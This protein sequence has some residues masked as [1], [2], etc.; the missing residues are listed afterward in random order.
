MRLLHRD[1]DKRSSSLIQGLIKEL[2]NKW[3]W[4]G[5]LSMLIIVTFVVYIPTYYGGF[6]WDDDFNFVNNP[7]MTADDGLKLIWVSEEAFYY[8]LV[9]TTFW[10]ERQLWG[11]N[12]F[13][14]HI[15]NTA[16]HAFNAVLLWILLRR[17][18]VRG[19]WLAGAI[20]AVHPL[21]V[22]SVAWITELKN[23]QSGFFYLLALLSY[24][25]FDKERKW[26]WYGVT[27]LLFV[28]ALLSKTSTVMLPV[29]L[30]FYRWWEGRSWRWRDISYTAPFFVIS[31][32]AALW[33]VWEQQH[34]SGA[35]GTE[36]SL[37][38]LEKVLIAGR[39]VWFYLIKLLVPLNLTFFYPRWSIDVHH[40]GAYL[41]VVALLLV[42][43]LFWWR[44]ATWGPS[45]AFGVGCY[46][47]SL[48]PVLGF[49]NIYFMRYSF[50]ADHFQ[51][52]ASMASIP[53]FI[54]VALYGFDQLRSHGPGDSERRFAVKM[55]LG[56]VVLLLLGVLTWRLGSI[57]ENEEILWVDT[58]QKNPKAWM[59]HNNLGIHYHNQGK[60]GD[61]IRALQEAVALKPDYGDAYYNLGIAYAR[62]GDLNRAVESYRAAADLEPNDAR[63]LHDLGVV[64]GEAGRFNEAV[65]ELKA[66]LSLRP[67]YVD[68]HR[69]LAALY[70][71][72]GRYGEAVEE[73]KRVLKIEPGSADV[74]SN[75]G[76][77]YGQLGHLD[78]AI[79]AFEEALRIEPDSQEARQNLEKALAMKRSRR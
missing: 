15:V 24:T 11:L 61:A 71:K 21:Q 39:I 66:A 12:P 34:H 43:L 3:L 25:L 16:F 17:L 59:A 54:S 38:L 27:M 5:A 70:R 56:A 10:V 78:N 48:F 2:D 49:F 72:N 64:Y 73:Y 77:A 36:W 22:E 47:V 40:A 60:S 55:V 65:Q 20:F 14:Y 37:G 28:L 30:L 76:V 75:L 32:F 74:Y 69:S 1:K 67:R 23:V 9:L 6:I 18:K 19:A 29:V 50:V 62:K 58:I 8:P 41:P 79:T 51:Y 53:L 4:W 57:Y 13:G 42:P 46:L 44:R 31:M 26:L 7:L 45:M 52:L 33:T 35:V 68:A 63:I